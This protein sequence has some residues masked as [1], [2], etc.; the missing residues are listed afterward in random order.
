MTKQTTIVVIGALRVKSLHIQQCSFQG[1][2][3][4][5]IFK[6]TRMK[7]QKLSPLY[8]MAENLTKPSV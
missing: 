3:S 5:V 1:L 7:S 8:E 6:V 2:S 4:I